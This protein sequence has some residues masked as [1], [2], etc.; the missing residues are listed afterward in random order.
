[1]A[2]A[3][4]YLFEELAAAEGRDDAAGWLRNVVQRDNLNTAA[5]T[6]RSAATDRK[7]LPPRHRAAAPSARRPAQDAQAPAESVLA[8]ED[9]RER[10]KGWHGKLHSWVERDRSHETKAGGAR[11][12]D[13]AVK[14]TIGAWHREWKSCGAL[15]LLQMDDPASDGASEALVAL[16]WGLN[17]E[18]SRAC[19]Q[20]AR[21]VVSGQE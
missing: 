1:M 16:A 4:A 21:P 15:H 2:A 11:C 12:H 7:I 9:V 6:G 13:A 10:V 18:V 20:K 3:T 8:S 14:P 17:I 19:I 5:R